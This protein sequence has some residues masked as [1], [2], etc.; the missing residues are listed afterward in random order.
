MLPGTP[1][2]VIGELTI[3]LS[4]TAPPPTTTTPPAPFEYVMLQVVVLGSAGTAVAATV[5]LPMGNPVILSWH[6]SAAAVCGVATQVGAV[7]T[8]C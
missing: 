7:G 8:N 1:G 4:G 3:R 5:P 2:N 6:V